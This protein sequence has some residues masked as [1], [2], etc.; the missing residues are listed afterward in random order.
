M[1]CAYVPHVDHVSHA[2]GTDSEAY[3][4][5]VATVCDQIADCIERTDERTTERTLLL[6][7]ADH[8]HVNTAPDRNIDL[9]AKLDGNGEPPTARGRNICQDGW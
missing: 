7:T 3:C 9:S 2:E 5:T 8:G 1:F 6:V 4:D